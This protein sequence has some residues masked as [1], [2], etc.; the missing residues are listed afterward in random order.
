[1]NA[2][3][4]SNKTQIPITGS[5]YDAIAYIAANHP[6]DNFQSFYYVDNTGTVNDPD[7]CTVAGGQLATIFNYRISIPVGSPYYSWNVVSPHW[8]DFI[9]HVQSLGFSVSITTPLQTVNQLISDATAGAAAIYA[10]YKPCLCLPVNNT[11][12]PCPG[13]I[14]NGAST[15]NFVG[16][17]TPGTVYYQY[18]V[19]EYP[20][21]SGS[22]WYLTVYPLGMSYPSQIQNPMNLDGWA[23]CQQSSGMPGGPTGTG[24]GTGPGGPGP[25]GG[26]DCSDFYAT[27]QLIQD[28]CCKYCDGPPY[29]PPIPAWCAPYCSC[30]PPDVTTPASCDCP[31]IIILMPGTSNEVTIYTNNANA[32]VFDSSSYYLQGDVYE[33]DWS[34][35]GA[36]LVAG[37]PWL[38]YQSLPPISQTNPIPYLTSPFWPTVPAGQGTGNYAACATQCLAEPGPSCYVYL[39]QN[40]NLSVDTDGD[41]IPDAPACI[42]WNDISSQSEIQQQV[43]CIPLIYENPSD[44]CDGYPQPSIFADNE[45]YN[46]NPD[47]SWSEWRGKMKQVSRNFY[48]C[49]PDSTPPPPP[50]GKCMPRLTKEEFLMNVSQKPEIRSD[51][52]IERGKTSPFERTQRL[53]QTPTI[54]ELELHGYGYY[55][56][57]EEKY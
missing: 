23:P 25:T 10:E 6:Y 48:C 26:I 55:K 12:I 47:G 44:G 35:Q 19:A 5:S 18:D 37:Q 46:L 52:F 21:G 36:A 28:D 8:Y 16:T 24:I 22:Y 54:G 20:A 17:Y 14:S 38:Q 39:A 15:T 49:V 33:L 45:F 29:A 30:C 27:S 41:G 51:V 43:T 4:C 11:S 32:T 7:A 57:I 56:I 9:T 13:A 31:D 2:F 3:D 1:M 53:A 34:T 42:P 40:T 50:T